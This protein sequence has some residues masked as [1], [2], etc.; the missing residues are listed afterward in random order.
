M[1]R[2]KRETE[3]TIKAHFRDYQEGI[4]FQYLFKFISG[5]ADL[6]HEALRDQFIAHQADLSNISDLISDHQSDREETTRTLDEFLREITRIAERIDTLTIKL[7]G[8]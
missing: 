8:G 6:I 3:R 1:R 7:T 4:K 2:M 5:Y